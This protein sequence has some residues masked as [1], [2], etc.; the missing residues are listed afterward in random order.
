M[1]RGFLAVAVVFGVGLLSGCTAVD[2]PL[3]GVR[4]AANGT[5][6]ALPGHV[7]ADD[8]AMSLGEFE[9]LAE[10]SC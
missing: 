5:P 1:R 9:R 2:L 10:D 4:V 7:W 8:R 3:A 6:Y